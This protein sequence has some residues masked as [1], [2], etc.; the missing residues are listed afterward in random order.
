[1][2]PD[3]DDD[4]V[5]GALSL[6]KMA[7]ICPYS[8]HNWPV[9]IVFLPYR[10]L[11]CFTKTLFSKKKIGHTLTSSLYFFMGWGVIWS[12]RQILYRPHTLRTAINFGMI[13]TKK[14]S[15]FLTLAD[16]KW[17]LDSG[18]GFND[19]LPPCYMQNED[20]GAL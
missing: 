1:M 20:T 2:L 16:L 17:Y 9:S 4:N 15:H 8:S 5:F 14:K 3:I 7:I 12:M 19:P 13:L 10:P 11:V 18:N 6:P